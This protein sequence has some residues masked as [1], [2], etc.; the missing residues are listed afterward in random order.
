MEAGDEG[1][2]DTKPIG[3][4]FKESLSR[5]VSDGPVFSGGEGTANILWAFYF[6]HFVGRVRVIYFRCG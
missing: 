6:I 4:I 2:D 5:E 3:E 1:R